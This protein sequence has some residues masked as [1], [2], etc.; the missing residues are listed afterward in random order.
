MSVVD[1]RNAAITEKYDQIIDLF[2]EYQKTLNILTSKIDSM[3]KV[4][5]LAYSA[6]DITLYGS[7]D[8]SSAQLMKL[9]A[10]SMFE[11]LEG[12]AGSAAWIKV[13]SGSTVGYIDG[14]SA[15]LL[16]N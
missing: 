15:V 7:A 11:I 9:P 10:N 5:V 4:R 2:K 1:R 3:T 16:K 6:K 8:A 13:L 12:D 14:R